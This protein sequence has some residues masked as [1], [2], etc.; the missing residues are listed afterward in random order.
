MTNKKDRLLHCRI[1]TLPFAFP[2]NPVLTFSKTVIIKCIKNNGRI[3]V[4]ICNP[5]SGPI[6]FFNRVSLVNSKTPRRILPVFFTDNYIS[7]MPGHSKTIVLEYTTRP[8]AAPPLVSV[9]GWNV[10]EACYP[11]TRTQKSDQ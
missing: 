10:D 1:F 11:V 3:A 4:T 6:A 9:T 2:V 7:V 8:D 5:A